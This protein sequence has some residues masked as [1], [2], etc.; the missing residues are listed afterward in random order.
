MNGDVP[1]AHP[2][3]FRREANRQRGAEATQVR[4]ERAV[5]GAMNT[6]PENTLEDDSERDSELYLRGYID[7]E[8]LVRRARE[9]VQPV[10]TLTTSHVKRF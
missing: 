10:T 1:Q 4:R 8:E 2:R 5:I 7:A 9:R 6:T 3:R